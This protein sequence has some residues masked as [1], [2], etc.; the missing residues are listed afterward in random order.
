[1]KFPFE[2]YPAHPIPTHPNRNSVL[3]PTIPVYLINK[4]TGA[5][6]GY[7][8]LIDSGADYC[9][10]HA[11]IGETIG[12]NIQNGGK[13]EYVGV[14]GVKQA[15]YFHNVILSIGGWK[16]NTYIGFS[17]DFDKI[18]MPY[19]VLGQ[20]GFFDKFKIVLDI[21]KPEIELKENPNIKFTPFA[22]TSKATI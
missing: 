14:S 2:R 15:A 11:S 1:M 17:Y 10:F 21:N 19:G 5:D 6:I 7:L 13:M 16:F 20:D 12:L 22:K 3:R 4:E 18:E 9:I 8:A